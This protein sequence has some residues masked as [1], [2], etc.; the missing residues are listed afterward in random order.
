[1]PDHRKDVRHSGATC[2]PW[3]AARDPPI[4][5]DLEE[6]GSAPGFSFGPGAG[7]RTDAM[8]HLLP[9]GDGHG[10]SAFTLEATKS[11]LRTLS[12]AMGEERPMCIASGLGRI[13]GTP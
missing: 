9:I 4:T 2:T 7:R 3:P 6:A 12:D 10:M 8:G 11:L 5:G 1:M 13:V